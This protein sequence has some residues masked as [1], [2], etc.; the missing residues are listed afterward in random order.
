MAVNAEI[1]YLAAGV[2][3]IAGGYRSQGQFPADGYKAV[4]ATTGLVILAS[5]SNDTKLAPLVRA[6]GFVLFMG[7]L[8][9]AVKAF[10]TPAKKSKAQ[11]QADKRKAANNG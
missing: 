11:V 6:V 5:A 7:A 10:Q 3:A 1:P 2:T 8:Y 9:G 4:L